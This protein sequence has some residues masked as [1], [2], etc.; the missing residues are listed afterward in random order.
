MASEPSQQTF[1]CDVGLIGTSNPIRSML[2]VGIDVYN[3]PGSA[4]LSCRKWVAEVAV[5]LSL[6]SLLELCW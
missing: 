1:K 6:D 5:V 3:V 2:P 4:V